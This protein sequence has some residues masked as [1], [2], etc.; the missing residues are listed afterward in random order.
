MWNCIKIVKIQLNDQLPNFEITTNEYYDF[1]CKIMSLCSFM[2][3]Y[4]QPACTDA[5]FTNST[6]NL[7]DINIQASAK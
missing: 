4:W 5:A 7:Q 6:I 2:A 3:V 1:S